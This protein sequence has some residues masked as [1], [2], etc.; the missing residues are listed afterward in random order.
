MPEFILNTRIEMDSFFVANLNLCQIRLMNNQYF[1]WFLLIPRLNSII[2]LTDLSFDNQYI[3]MQELNQV[4]I[5]VQKLFNPTRLNI[6]SLGNIV[7]QMHWHIIARYDTDKAWPNPVWGFQSPQYE[8]SQE[9]HII[10]LFQ[11]ALL[12]KN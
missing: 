5:I 10:T 7:P 6:A 12:N 9:N 11:N 8:N 4:A 2:N 3:L 1:T